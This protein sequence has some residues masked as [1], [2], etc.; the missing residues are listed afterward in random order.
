MDFAIIEIKPEDKIDDKYFLTLN[1]NNKNFIDENIMIFQY[2]LGQKLSKSE[3][4]II[5]INN[6][7]LYHNADTKIGSSGSPIFLKGTTEVIGMHK[8]CH[9]IKKEKLGIKFYSIFQLIN[10]EKKEDLLQ[11]ETTDFDTNDSKEIEAY[12][13]GE[14]LDYKTHGKG[15]LFDKNGNIIYDGYFVNNYYEGDGKL[16]YESGVIYIGQFLKGERHGKGIL[17]Y[18]NGNIKYEGDFV[19]D[20]KEGNGKFIW[21]NGEYYIGQWKNDLPYVKG[22]IY[23]KSGNIKYDGDFIKA[24]YEGNGKY[25]WEDGEYYFGQYLNGLKHGKGKIYY[26]NGNIKYDGDFDKGQFEGNGKY[27]Y[28]NGEY[29][30]G[31]FLN[32][33]KHGKGKEY[34][35][36]GNIKYDGEFIKGK[37]IG[38]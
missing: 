34:Y 6:Y 21:E 3:G 31:Q 8:A 20:K 33:L 28:E 10:S 13:I 26:K 36:N 29:Y 30:I 7:K 27:I 9:K 5:R 22:T 32:G 38:K 35:K 2:P 17:Y 14:I 11:N 12:Y 16:V 23:Y 37:F 18:K 24:K 19:H 15:I 1:L 25:I 4:K